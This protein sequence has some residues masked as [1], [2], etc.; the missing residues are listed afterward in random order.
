MSERYK[1]GLSRSRLF[2]FDNRVC[3]AAQFGQGFSV[4]G[5]DRGFKM[6]CEKEP[7]ITAVIELDA[8]GEAFAVTH[9]AEQSLV[10]ADGTAKEL[11]LAKRR[12]SL[13]F[14]KRLFE[15]FITDD[16]LV[17]FAHTAVADVK[18]LFIL[19]GELNAFAGRRLLNIEP[20][21][22]LLFSERD[23]LMPTLFSPLVDSVTSELEEGWRKKKRVFGAADY[24]AAAAAFEGSRRSE[25]L[26]E[27]T[28]PEEAAAAFK[29]RCTLQKLDCSSA[30]CFA[31]YKAAKP[32]LHGTKKYYRISFGTDKRLYLE[33]ESRIGV[34]PFSSGVTVGTPGKK[35]IAKLG[36]LKAYH[37]E[38]YQKF[39]SAFQAFYDETFLMLLS[40]S[41][42]DAAYMYAAQLYK[43][44]YAKKLA[45]NHTCLAPRMMSFYSY[46]PDT[47]FGQELAGFDNIIAFEP[48]KT[49]DDIFV[50]AL[51]RNGEIRLLVFYNKDKLSAEKT[52]EIFKKAKELL[53]I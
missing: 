40:P 3:F 38:L 19:A 4:N 45:L 28:I 15:F 5:L 25:G 11:V 43:G 9:S 35:N 14:S 17:I 48:F 26:C 37:D 44:K 34:G 13:D 46:T 21:G 47:A 7:L 42:C 49:R 2:E 29:E 53:E 24:R 6:L 41:F 12:E 18:S 30:L 27:F 10:H 51:T 31:F 20:S 32:M 22:V 8:D 33:N 1:L 52:E 36:E 50:T 16:G 39:S 23:E